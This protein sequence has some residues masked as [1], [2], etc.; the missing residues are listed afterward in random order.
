MILYR[1]LGNDIRVRHGERQTADAMAFILAQEPSLRGCEKRFLLNR[2]VDRDY[3]AELI[4][5]IEARE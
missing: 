5:A 4:A 3:E 2:V 1:I